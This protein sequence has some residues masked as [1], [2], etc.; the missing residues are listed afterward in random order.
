MP[1]TIPGTDSTA[2]ATIPQGT[3]VPSNDQSGASGDGAG[4]TSAPA[5]GFDD[6]FRKRLE[7]L[8]WSKIDPTT[9]PQK[10]NEQF[11]PKPVFTKKA[12]EIADER[13]ALAE[14][15]KA[16]FDVTRKV[17]A[18]RD[19]PRGPTP[20]QQKVAQL[21]ELA[22]AGDVD[23]Q[24]QLFDMKVAERVG[25]IE[26]QF[27]YTQA[28]TRAQAAE[29]FVGKYWNDIQQ[30]ID[31]TPALQELA[32]FQGFKYADKVYQALGIER[33]SW[34]QAKVI[35][36]QVER[37]KTLETKLSQYEKERVSGLPQSTTKAG[38]TAGRPVA[39]E[40]DTITDAAKSAW[41]ES[42]GRL[43]DFR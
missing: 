13:R 8:D 37:I 14:R 28:V 1:D 4:T 5:N 9:L 2:T 3:D 40:A 19:T 34:E 29:P 27:A 23:A 36:E 26:S 16:I 38:T 18:E 24:N 10:F 25:P 20:A 15:E 21:Q 39:G 22:A 43:E 41:L 42:G 6:D 17:L 31:A 33:K 30:A 32:A 12:Q 7:E 11:V 35:T